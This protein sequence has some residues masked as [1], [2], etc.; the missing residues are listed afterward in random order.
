MTCFFLRWTGLTALLL[1]VSG[2]SAHDFWV[3]PN[4]FR[5]ESAADIEVSLR[6]GVAFKGDTLPYISDWFDDFSQVTNEG[7]VPVSSVLGNDPAAIL[8]V[9]PGPLLLGYQSERSFVELDAAKFNLYLEHEGIEFI[10]AER[11][12]RGEDDDPAPEYFIRCAKTL[13]QSG[14]VSGD[15]Y[16]TVLGYTL[17]L[18]PE[19]DPY[20]LTVGDELS[21]RLSYRNE[22]PEGLL[23][24]AFTRDDPETIQKVRTDAGGRATITLDRPGV[25]LVKAVNI[26]PISG[27]PKALWQSYWATYLFELSADPG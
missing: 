1:T 17:E 7:R 4:N 13:L 10:R 22:V 26:E 19:Q 24:Q 12:A 9:K 14:D 6:Q 5:P 8:V 18:V 21:F 15:V 16:K 25:W 27:D 11:Q 3:E 20:G 2:V 23:I